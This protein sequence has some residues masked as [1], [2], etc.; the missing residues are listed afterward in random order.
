MRVHWTVSNPSADFNCVRSVSGTP[1]RFLT[2]VD[3][4]YTRRVFTLKK[5]NALHTP[6]KHVNIC[7]LFCTGHTQGGV[8]S[9]SYFIGLTVMF[10]CVPCI[11]V[12]NIYI[13]KYK[14]RDGYTVVHTQ[15]YTCV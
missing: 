6:P 5:D 12:P 14:H 3:D 7:W 13:I 9:V 8:K 1:G 10:V 15:L 11:D 2:N 4:T